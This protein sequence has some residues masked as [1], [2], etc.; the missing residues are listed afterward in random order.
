MGRAGGYAVRCGVYRDFP[1]RVEAPGTASWFVLRCSD[2]CHVIG[3]LLLL[4]VGLTGFHTLQKGNYGRIGRADFYTVIVAALVQIVAQV[5]LV[6]GS[7]ALEDLD[8]LGSS[9]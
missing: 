4:L 6:L 2:Q 8:L 9:A 7:S 5:V 3:A 1:Y